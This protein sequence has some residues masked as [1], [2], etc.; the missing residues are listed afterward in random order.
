R[1]TADT[2]RD[3]IEECELVPKAGQADRVPET[4][5]RDPKADDVRERV[6]LAAHRRGLV[7]PTSD[8]SVEDVEDE[9]QND[10]AS[11]EV[12]PLAAAI[13]EKSDPEE[14]RCRSAAAVCKREEV[15]EVKVADH[16]EMA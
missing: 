13:A 3:E 10:E 6:E 8:P 7:A 15:R 5:R 4:R 16:R 14:D 2:A 11:S 1:Q 9:G 12:D